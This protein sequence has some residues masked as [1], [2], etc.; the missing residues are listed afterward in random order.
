[1]KLTDL[2]IVIP[3]YGKSTY[4]IEAL[5]S[6]EQLLSL[7]TNLLIIDDGATPDIV[8]VI[9]I[10]IASQDSYRINV[11]VN[12]CNLGLFNSLNQNIKLVKTEWLC[13]LCSD[14]FFLSDAA[15]K[16]WKLQPC[17]Q[18]SL[19]LS[20]FISVNSDR[21]IRYDDCP[22]LQAIQSEYGN[23]LDGN[24]APR[25]ITVWE[26]KRKPLRND[27]SKNSL[28]DSRRLSP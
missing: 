7:G 9:N 27:Y 20:R 17:D 22:Q 11:H 10:W 21:S 25:F 23:I 26:C 1:M 12:D 15:L 13:F 6:L 4:L 8:T 24:H 19:I 14:D 18:S 2:T 3:V 16:L 28:G 5:E